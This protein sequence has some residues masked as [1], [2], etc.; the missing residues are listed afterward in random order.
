MKLNKTDINGKYFSLSV[1]IISDINCVVISEIDSMPFC[2][3]L[4]DK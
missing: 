4:G 3:A 1:E 2:H